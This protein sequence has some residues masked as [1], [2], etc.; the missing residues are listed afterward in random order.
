MKVKQSHLEK[1]WILNDSSSNKSAI[2][3]LPRQESKIRKPD[4]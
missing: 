4:A 3:V 2:N 1:S